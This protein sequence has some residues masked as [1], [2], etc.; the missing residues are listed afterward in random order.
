MQ[1]HIIPLRRRNR[2]LHNQHS[3]EDYV[4]Y[5]LRETL[6]KAQAAGTAIGHFNVADLVMLKAVFASA[7]EL[8]V[9]V[10]VGASE[11]GSS[12]RLLIRCRKWPARA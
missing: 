9:P 10:L 5:A 1:S 4:M 11:G 8:K 3:G 7:R 6:A 2:S 12:P